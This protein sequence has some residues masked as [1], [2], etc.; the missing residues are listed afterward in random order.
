MIVFTHRAQ[1]REE[2]YISALSLPRDANAATFTISE[3]ANWRLPLVRAAHARTAGRS[4]HGNVDPH[5]ARGSF[6]R[7][8]ASTL[9]GPDAPCLPGLSYAQRDPLRGSRVVTDH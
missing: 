6:P 4:A 3:F 8:D 2:F 5:Q 9:R 1:V 7:V